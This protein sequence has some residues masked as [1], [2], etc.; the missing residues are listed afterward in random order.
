MRH[1]QKVVAYKWLRQQ[2]A[3]ARSRSSDPSGVGF[4][5]TP[6]DVWFSEWFRWLDREGII[7][8][9]GGNRPYRILPR[10][11]DIVDEAE[12]NPLD[13]A[14]PFPSKMEMGLC[15]EP[16]RG[17]RWTPMEI[18]A[19][20]YVPTA[21]AGW[22]ALVRGMAFRKGYAARRVTGLEGRIQLEFGIPE[23]DAESGDQVKIDR[24]QREALE[25]VDQNL[26]KQD[27]EVAAYLEARAKAAE[28]VGQLETSLA[29]IRK[30][31]TSGTVGEAIE[32]VGILGKLLGR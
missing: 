16:H 14:W 7:K 31:L 12:E 10:G 5:G 6:R 21:L 25:V 17:F 24:F 27:M 20:E 9:Y 1:A 3:E 22:D 11:V 19:D 32:L 28:V 4:T 8:M 26:R 30:D 18:A 29:G 2:V 15:G 13:S 23:E